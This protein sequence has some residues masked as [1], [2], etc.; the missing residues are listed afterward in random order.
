MDKITKITPISRKNNESKTDSAKLK[1]YLGFEYIKLKKDV[2]GLDYNIDHLREFG[3]NQRYIITLARK[4]NK[5]TFIYNFFVEGDKLTDFFKSCF[6]G[7]IE[8]DIIDIDK[9]QPENLA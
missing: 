9:L 5:D 7:K 1:A 3:K 2:N 4:I 6:N 8:G